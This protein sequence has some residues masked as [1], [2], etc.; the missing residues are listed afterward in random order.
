MVWYVLLYYFVVGLNLDFI[1]SYFASFFLLN[2]CSTRVSNELGAENPQ[3]AKHAMMVTLKLSV[4]AALAVVLL[5]AFGHDI[6]AGFFS[7]SSVIIKEFAL[8][9][10]FLMV[11]IAID[12]LQAILSGFSPILLLLSFL[13]SWW[14]FCFQI[15]EFL[16][17]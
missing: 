7:N 10:P 16:Y 9:T 8:L 12:F 1:Y 4:L 17:N 6:W 11:S 13:Y 3:Q 5:L 15:N 2:W 14:Y